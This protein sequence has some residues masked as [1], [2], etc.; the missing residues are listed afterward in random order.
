MDHIENIGNFY[1][2]SEYVFWVVHH[3]FVPIDS[4]VS[5]KFIEA[6]SAHFRHIRLSD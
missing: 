5:T 3:Y 2:H 6:F 4:A 1:T